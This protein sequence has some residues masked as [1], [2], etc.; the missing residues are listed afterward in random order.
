MVVK[1]KWDVLVLGGARDFH[2]MDWYHAIRRLFPEGKVVFAT[3]SFEAEGS[4]DL[5]QPGDDVTSLL[6][7]DGFLASRVSRLGNIWR[8]FLK[9]MLVPMQALILRRMWVR[10]GRPVVHAH[11]MYFMLMAR[12]AR[13]P[14]IGTPQGS[15]LLVRPNISRVYRHMAAWVMR[16]A[17]FVIVDSEAMR[18]AAR[19]I[20]GVDAINIQNGINV[21]L[22]E[23]VRVPADNERIG[24]VS[25]RGWNPL[26]RIA[27]IISGRNFSLPGQPLTFVYPFSE[28]E[29]AE[30]IRAVLHPSDIRL[31]RLDKRE[32]YK[33]LKSTLL[34]VSIPASDSS[35]RSVYESIFCGCCVATTYSPWVDALPPSMRDRIFL[36]DLDDPDWFSRACAFARRKVVQSFEPDS[37]ALSMFDEDQSL[38][39]V[40]RQYYLAGDGWRCPSL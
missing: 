4:H 22:I 1:T 34:V 16:G 20:S 13:I 5:R 26:Y 31:G 28:H 7:I 29:Y 14:Y 15:E 40:V 2:A 3:D 23:A 33:L 32:L 18:R 35:P 30:R 12:I 39:R 17:K 19:E 24:V 38:R 8:N 10:H 6:V 27:E 11:P 36:V 21:S 9:L 25:I 37:I